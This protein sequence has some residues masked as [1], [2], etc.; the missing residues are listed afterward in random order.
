MDRNNASSKDSGKCGSFPIGTSGDK[1]QVA[2]DT[3]CDAARSRSVENDL[4]EPIQFM[5]F[6]EQ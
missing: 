4:N 1:N 3:R 6:Y 2:E 5:K